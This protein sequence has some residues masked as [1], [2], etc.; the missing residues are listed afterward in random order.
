MTPACAGLL[1][2]RVSELGLLKSTFNGEN[3]YV[4][5]LGLSPAI[6]LQFSVEMY[7][8]IVKD[9]LKTLLGGSWSLKV[10][11]VDN[12]ENFVTSACYDKQH[13]WV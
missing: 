6:S 4:G 7:P 11:D 3:L 9:S 2:L 13:V 10:I 1:E 5:C 8:K 12:F